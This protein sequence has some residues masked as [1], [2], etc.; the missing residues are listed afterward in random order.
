M[1]RARAIDIKRLT[2]HRISIVSNVDL[3]R[4]SDVSTEIEICTRTSRDIV[5]Y[6]RVGRILRTGGVP[7][8]GAN[9]V[10][11]LVRTSAK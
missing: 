9:I 4:L 2:A 3:D 11:A 10:W 1:V 6:A 8:Y 5:K 7:G